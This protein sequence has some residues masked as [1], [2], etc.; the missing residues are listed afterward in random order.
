MPEPGARNLITD[1][2]GVTV[3][4]ATDEGAQTGVSVLRC[5]EQFVA[6]VDAR[7]GA[8]GTRET[9][10]LQSE[11]LVGRADAIVL[12]GG[13]VFGLA[14]ADGVACALSAANIGLR[15]ADSGPAI[16]IVPAA[17]LHDLG[18]EGDKAW[19]EN[20]PYRELGAQALAAAAVDF[21]LGAVGAG[22]GAMAGAVIGGLGSASVVLDN[23]VQVG[24]LV[25]ANPAGSVLMPDGDAFYAWPWE[26]GKEFGGRKPPVDRDIA[27]PFAAY[28]RFAARPKAGANTIIA[29]V[30]TSADLGGPEAK[31]IA[32]M[33]HDGIARAV[34]P[35]HT[36]FD[37][38]VI[39]AVA[40]AKQKLPA[41]GDFMRPLAIA[42]IG[43]AAGDCVARAIARAV[44]CA[45]SRRKV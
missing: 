17:V 31:R 41:S 34:R 3:G 28:S 29:V 19:G 4:N 22:R 13:S 16:P 2:A 27:S 42:E 30:A 39:F 40:T 37:G 9:N 21:Q 12:A 33:A 23:G 24:A 43:G 7:G 38:D 15:M 8:P 14:A 10:V 44:Y 18:N 1:V 45:R 32:I 25:G 35:A 20:P 11:N 6:A 26:H 36:P 5:A